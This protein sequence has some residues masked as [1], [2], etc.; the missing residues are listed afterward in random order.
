MAGYFA[1]S[2]R[3]IIED[4]TGP[5]AQRITRLPTE[6]KIP[7]SNPGRIVCLIT[8]PVIIFVH[9][10]VRKEEKFSKIEKPTAS[11]IPKRSPIQVL[12]GLDVA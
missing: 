6:Q 7:G 4:Q 12:T 10:T 1:P 3:N 5:V 2:L 11:R 8:I 9:E